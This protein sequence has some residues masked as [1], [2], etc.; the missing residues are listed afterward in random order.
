MS[1]WQR[2]LCGRYTF[3]LL[4]QWY[5]REDIYP[6]KLAQ[7][8]LNRTLRLQAAISE[9]LSKADPE[10]HYEGST[11]TEVFCLKLKSTGSNRSTTPLTRDNSPLLHNKV[12]P[13]P[14]VSH[15][16]STAVTSPSQCTS[17]LGQI[18]TPTRDLIQLLSSQLN[19]NAS[20]FTNSGRTCCLPGTLLEL[21]GPK[22]NFSNW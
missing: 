17:N 12:F 13:F 22:D 1:S 16:H 15:R 10:A 11:D 9:G 18:S 2:E 7:K 19:A 20:N 21:P 3:L 6:R 8:R 4:R 5:G 14:S